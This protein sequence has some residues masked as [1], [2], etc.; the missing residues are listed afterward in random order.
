MFQ[1]DLTIIIIVLNSLTFFG[2]GY[3]L[4][5]REC[6][7]K[8]TLT[9][10]NMEKLY[11]ETKEFE[12]PIGGMERIEYAPPQPRDNYPTD[13]IR[14]Q[15]VN[16]P[17]GIITRPTAEELKVMGEDEETKAAKRAI[18]ETFGQANTE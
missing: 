3:L 12:T 18:A 16:E 4:S 8:H 13:G 14:Y 10:R 7:S 1:L 2:L 15:S 11:E 5:N 17:S 9:I 6:K